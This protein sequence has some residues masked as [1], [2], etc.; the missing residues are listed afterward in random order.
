MLEK[1]P[2]HNFFH[3]RHFYEGLRLTIGIALPTFIMSWF[4]HLAIG[5]TMSLGAL[6]VSVADNPGP[7][8]HRRI[9]MLITLALVTALTIITAWL[10]DTPLITGILITL[11]GFFFSM[12]VVYG[13]RAASIGISALLIIILSFQTNP[14]G[15]DIYLQALH[16]FAGGMWYFILSNVLHSLRPYKI[17]QQVLGDYLINIAHYFQSRTGFYTNDSNFET[18]FEDIFEQQVNVQTQQNLLSDLIFNTRKIVKES[19]NTSRRLLKIYLDATD[20]FE[21][22]MSSHEDYRILQKNFQDTGILSA[23]HSQMIKLSEELESIGINIKGGRESKANEILEESMVQ[24]REK[25]ESLRANTINENNVENFVG[26]G[27][28]ISNIQYVTNQIQ[29]LHYYTISSKKVTKGSKA[30]QHAGMTEKQRIDPNLYFDNFSFKSNIFRHS[31]RVALA[32]LIG[33]YVSMVLH[34]VHNAWILLTILVILKPAYQLTKTRNKDR[35]IGTILGIFL[36]AGIL[37]VLKLNTILL[38]VM[39]LLMIVAYTFMRTNYFISVLALTTYLVIFYHFLYPTSLQYVITERLFDTFIGSTIAFLASLFI[40]PFWEH[41]NIGLPMNAML[42]SGKKYFYL[43]SKAYTD[44]PPSKIEIN[45]SRREMYVA[46]ANVTGAFNRMLSEPRRFQK[47]IKGVYRFA[48]LNHIL[49][50]HL[51]ALVYYKYSRNYPIQ[52]E[53]ITPLAKAIEDNF[54]NAK[55]YLDG[56]FDALL[57]VKSNAN[58]EA[59]NL[60]ATFLNQRKT[61]LQNGVLESE[62][63]D[64]LIEHKAVIGQFNHIFTLSGEIAKACKKF[65]EEAK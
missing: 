53:K 7:I 51:A 29:Q 56:N 40:V 28:I 19:T 11:A 1:K 16:V 25:F 9:G 32:M 23:I 12:L 47:G 45:H 49:S 42:D 39:V 26:L 27:R 24:L 63:K 50:S 44:T 54:S 48:V 43:V 21:N 15:K 65:Q 64:K 18:V 59:N 41:E 17:V 4:G 2:Y 58:E 52:S 57:I 61:E 62:T 5:I 36:G 60:T 34:L 8:H 10:N 38:S 20:L 46:L 30:L 33:F 31:V 3:D 55:S 22:I 13:D 14:K 37:Y 35:L 6:C